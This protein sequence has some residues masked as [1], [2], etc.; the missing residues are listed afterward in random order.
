MLNLKRLT[1][2]S[3][4]IVSLGLLTACGDDN[5]DTIGATPNPN[6][7]EASNGLFIR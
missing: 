4:M 1:L 6:P 2:T 7:P 5:E 3:T